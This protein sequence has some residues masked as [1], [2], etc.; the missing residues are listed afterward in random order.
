MRHPMTLPVRCIPSPVPF[1]FSLTDSTP[2][3][4]R[5]TL[6][7]LFEGLRHRFHGND[8]KMA[9]FTKMIT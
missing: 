2:S 9:I 4:R 8:Q 1:M 6:P 7:Q 5:P 3:N